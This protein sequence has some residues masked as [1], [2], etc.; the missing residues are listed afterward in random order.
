M[1]R[2]SERIHVRVESFGNVGA[3]DGD[4]GAMHVFRVAE[5]PPD[6]RPGIEN[7]FV[8]RKRPVVVDSRN[9][10][11][12]ITG[13]DRP[14]A[15]TFICPSW[16]ETGGDRAH[17]GTQL[18]DGLGVFQGE[19][20]ARSFVGT[21]PAR[22]DAG[23]ETEDEEGFRA[24]VGQISVHVSIDTDKDRNHGKN[25]GDADDH[26]KNREKGA[27]LVLT[28]SGESH[29]SILTDVHAHRY[30]H[31]SHT[32]WRKASMGCRAAARRAG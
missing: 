14:G 11:A 8:G 3:D 12:E 29:L 6:F 10:L 27:H 32:S 2:F 24:V 31:G 5:E 7:F 9:F 15:R 21:E 19:R 18:P 23:I 20:F 1:D 26:A 16:I 28:Q 13:R 25:S 30:M 4:V 17:R 22:V